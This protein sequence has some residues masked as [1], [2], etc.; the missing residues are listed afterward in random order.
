MNAKTCGYFIV[1][2][3]IINPIIAIVT[4]TIQT[5]RIIKEIKRRR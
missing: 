1:T 3:L 5:E 4:S 2:M